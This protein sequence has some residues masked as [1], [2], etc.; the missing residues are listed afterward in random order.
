MPGDRDAPRIAAVGRD[1]VD[2]PA[3]RRGGIVDEGGKA[4]RRDQ[5]VIGHDDDEPARG[6]GPGGEGIAAAVTRIPPAA[7]EEHDNRQRSGGV[8]RHI[9]VELL[10]R[11]GT[12]GRAVDPSDHPAVAGRQRVEPIECREAVAPGEQPRGGEAGE[13]GAARLDHPPCVAGPVDLV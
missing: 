11:V 12:I 13:H 2:R 10:P 4:H 3:D 7:V 5:P 1:M 9:D 8:L 6:D